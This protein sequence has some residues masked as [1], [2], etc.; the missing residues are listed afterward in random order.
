MRRYESWRARQPTIST[1]LTTVYGTDNGK[2]LTTGRLAGVTRGIRHE[3]GSRSNRHIQPLSR[4]QI[5]HSES[6]GAS[7]VGG[8]AKSLP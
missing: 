3:K 2:T 1:F 5:G 6:F 7:V 8:L 4:M